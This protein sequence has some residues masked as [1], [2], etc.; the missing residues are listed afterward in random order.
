[1]GQKRKFRRS[2]KVD[3]SNP[4]QEEIERMISAYHASRKKEVPLIINDKL[5]IMVTPDKCNE[6]YRCQYIKAKSI[7]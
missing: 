6:R 7:K 5:T 1:M 4:D 3:L 2:A